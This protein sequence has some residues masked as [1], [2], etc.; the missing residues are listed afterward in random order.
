MKLLKKLFK[1]IFCIIF[2]PLFLIALVVTIQGYTLY[3]DVTNKTPLDN[4]I[5]QIKNNENY[6]IYS[7]IPNGIKDGTVAIE[8][9]RFFDHKGFDIISTT[10]AIITN[11]SNKKLVS[12]GSTITQ[13]LAK[14]LYFSQ[15]KKFS[16]K[17]AELI[18]AYELEKNYSKEEI[19]ELYL[20]I[21]YYGD[22]YTG[23]K[24]ASLG[25][26]NKLPKD[27]SLYEQTLLVA[28][29]NAPSV[30]ALSEKNSYT[31][32]RQKYVIDA[33]VKY[34]YLTN[35]ESKNILNTNY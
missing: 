27:L 16:R 2:I 33:M 9:H 15:N 17:I 22:G 7:Q 23:I 14:N 1:L 13:Q 26:F 28:L 3:K 21:I 5:K 34:N 11:I 32:T 24:N 29:P 35:D 8:D 31:Y 20:N 25:Y 6:I 4:K 18:V 10:R 30:Y 12:G 19:L